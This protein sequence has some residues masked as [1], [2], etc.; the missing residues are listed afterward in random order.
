MID[1]WSFS[2]ELLAAYKKVFVD[3]IKIVSYL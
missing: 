3:L 1:M 2:T